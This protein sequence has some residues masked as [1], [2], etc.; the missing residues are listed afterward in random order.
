MELPLGTEGRKAT[1]D[2]LSLYSPS[3]AHAQQDPQPHPG[4]HLKT[5]NF[6]QPLEREGKHDASTRE[7][8]RG[9]LAAGESP[10]VP[11]SAASVEHL[12]PGGIGTYSISYFNQ[13]ASLMPEGSLF[14]TA[15]TSSS[16]R[17]DE[18]SNCSSYTGSGFTL[19]DESAAKKGKTG[20]ENIAAQR[21][22]LQ[23][24]GVN[25]LGGQWTSLLDK[26]AQTSS[27][28]KHIP[29]TFSSSQLSSSRNN[30][31]FIDM[32]SAKDEH[33]EDD[34]D[35]E[36]D[37]FVIK[38]RSSHPKG[39]LSVK[40]ESK[41][42]DQ[43]PST[44]RS[45]HSATEQRRRSKIN[46]RFQKLREIIP[47]N[48][49]KRDKASFLLEVIEYIH[50]LQEKVNRYESP[51]NAWGHES[52]KMVQMSNG[53]GTEG[54]LKTESCSAPFTAARFDKN[55]ACLSPSIP[56]NG[57]TLLDSD[58][59]TGTTFRERGQHQQPEITPRAAPL[60]PT[61]QPSIFTYGRSNIA[62]SPVSPKPASDADKTMT[63]P[64]SQPL[65]NKLHTADRP[66]AGHET[67]IESGTINISSVYSQGLLDTL[68]KALNSSGVD[69][70]GACISVQVHLGKK[71]YSTPHSPTSM[72]K[73]DDSVVALPHP[74]GDDFGHTLKKLRSS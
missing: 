54:F 15:Q 39:N 32:I 59:S 45:K 7:E 14:T 25:V 35:D 69:L 22:V 71:A 1:H 11:A 46:D 17:N 34:D 29:A 64:P 66:D 26:P 38:D 10:L 63:W 37:G 12:L 33:E 24:A 65:Q 3:S 57:Q 68:T 36:E 9:G 53:H 43:K 19:W 56:T 13:R 44:P 58:T 62:A 60:H 52:S 30:Q 18:N 23:D 70:S 61:T 41:T 55:K 27:R 73:N 40:I 6:L 42:I 48:D 4:G 16:T 31:S 49:Q 2:F 28:H 50:F 51:Y 72:A 5:H 21:H 20:K 47:N 67:T 8:S 74:T